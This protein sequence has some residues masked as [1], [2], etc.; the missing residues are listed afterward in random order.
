M[1][2]ISKSELKSKLLELL[3][4]VESEKEELIVTDRGKPV[5]KIFRYYE[6]PTTEESFGSIRGKVVYSEDLTTPTT[7]VAI[8]SGAAKSSV[9]Q[10]EI[11]LFY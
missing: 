9:K 6:S 10:K 7:E 11:I 4:H 3:P 1:K 8:A 5:V 2:S